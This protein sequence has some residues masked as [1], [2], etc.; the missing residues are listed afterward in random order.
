MFRTIDWSGGTVVMLD[1]TRLPTEV[2]YRRYERAEEVA[3]AIRSMVI[4]GAP[5]IG[6]AAAMGI[7]LGMRQPG[8]TTM[9]DLERRMEELSKIFAATRPTAV[10]LFWAINRMKRTFDSARGLTP[11]ESVTV[12]E[13][14]ALIIQIGT[15][16]EY[17]E[18]AIQ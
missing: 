7:A 17:A 11:A 4:R 18:Y 2:I 15:R 3:E 14:E 9:Q 1:Q 16:P 8:G 13:K 5:A 10:N 12:L 6:V